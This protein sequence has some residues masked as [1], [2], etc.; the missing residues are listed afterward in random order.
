MYPAFRV[1]GLTSV[2]HG[3]PLR[4]NIYKNRYSDVLLTKSTR[5]VVPASKSAPLSY[6]QVSPSQVSVTVS[7]TTRPGGGSKVTGRSAWDA[8][9]LVANRIDPGSGALTGGLPGI[10][11]RR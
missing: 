2:R 8:D 3:P 6:V 11:S 1:P 10:A 4:V 7:E 9:Q 5:T